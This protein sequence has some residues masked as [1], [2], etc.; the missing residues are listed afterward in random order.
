MNK[1]IHFLWVS[2]CLVAFLDKVG[3]H[4]VE[5]I[6]TTF[7]SLFMISQSK[8]L[9]SP[10]ITYPRHTPAHPL[11]YKNLFS[12]RRETIVKSRL[13]FIVRHNISVIRHHFLPYSSIM[14]SHTTSCR[15]PL[16]TAP[17][18][19]QSDL[20]PDTVFHL[21]AFLAAWDIL[22]TTNKQT[23]RQTRVYTWPPADFVERLCSW[24]CKVDSTAVPS[25][26]LL[27]SLNN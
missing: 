15:N 17:N 14:K 7:L 21:N 23:Y 12:S 13:I 5:R 24:Y 3:E 11:T 20:V 1:I 10:I 26:F 27:T 19:N 9:L 22:Y 25:V 8:N 2:Y 16:L 4:S 18:Y 6:S